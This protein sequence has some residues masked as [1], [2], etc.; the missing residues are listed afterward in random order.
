MSLE[1]LSKLKQPG[2]GGLNYFVAAHVG[3]AGIKMRFT[4]AND[5]TNFVDLPLLKAQDTVSL[6]GQVSRVSNEFDNRFNKSIC[7]GAVVSIVG[8][9]KDGET[10]VLTNWAG[11]PDAR[12]ISVQQLPVKL[13]PTG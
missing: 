10:G 13:F 1:V 6:L 9:V 12:T 5:S 4:D 8:P 11:R 7:C 3:G 2:T